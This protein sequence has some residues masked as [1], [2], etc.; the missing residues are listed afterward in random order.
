MNYLHP[1]DQSNKRSLTKLYEELSLIQEFAA[2]KTKAELDF[3]WYYANP[4]SPFVK[5]I[6]D[7][8]DRAHKVYA[9]VFTGDNYDPGTQT[10]FRLLRF[11]EDIRVAIGP[12][13]MY[14]VDRRVRAKKALERSYDNY[15][16]I[17]EANLSG[18]PDT[19]IEDSQIALDP[20][21]ADE[22]SEKAGS[23]KKGLV[24]SYEKWVVAA[25]KVRDGMPKLLHAIEQGFGV[26]ESKVINDQMTEI[27]LFIEQQ[28]QN[29]K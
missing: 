28:T 5:M 14:K 1:P 3:V 9:Y 16:K 12:M 15:I 18:L 23:P 21:F 19:D 13:R 20:D 2:L 4:T 26:V 29:R 27:E 7:D 17:L 6:D 25:E 11:P 10:E 8:G 22:D 24:M